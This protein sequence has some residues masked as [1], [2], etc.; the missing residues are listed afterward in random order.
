MKE[1]RREGKLQRRKKKY[2]RKICSSGKE[3]QSEISDG[4]NKNQKKRD[5]QDRK[6]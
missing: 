4:T 2:A 6:I 1:A 3:S 5:V